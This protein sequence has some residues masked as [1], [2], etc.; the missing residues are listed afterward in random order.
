MKCK[1]LSG[2]VGLALVARASA[3]TA[4]Y[5]V[6]DGVVTTPPQID[7]LNFI[8]NGTFSFFL[9]S[10]ALPYQTANTITST[11]RGLMECDSGFRFDKYSTATGLHSPASNWVNQTTGTINCGVNT[12]LIFFI[13]PSTLTGSKC[14]VTASNIINRGT[15]NVASDGLT[16][17]KGASVDLSRGL[18]G[19][20]PSTF[21]SAFGSRFDGYWGFGD[22]TENPAQSFGT[23][24]FAP[25]HW[26]TNRYY[27]SLQTSLFLSPATPYSLDVI[28]GPSN[29]VVSAVFIRNFNPAFSNNVY[30]GGPGGIVTVEWVWVQTNFL[31]DVVSTNRMV[32]Q[33]SFGARTN[34]ALGR[35]G[36][37]APSTGSAASFT[38][39]NY[40]FGSSFF[41][42][43]TPAP[44][45]LPPGG[46]NNS[47]TT[48]EY[49]AYQAIFSGSSSLIGEVANQSFSQLPGRIEIDAS[50]YLDLNRAR[51]GALN[52]LS[53]KATNHFAGT[54]LARIA[55][56]F[57][58]MDLKTTNGMLVISNLMLPS[59]PRLE[60]TVDLFSA[61]WTNVDAFNFTNRYHVLLVNS[62][63]SPS[64]VPQFQELNLRSTNVIINDV[65]N[66]F[67]NFMSEAESLT[68]ASNSPGAD[69]I[70]GQINLL[71]GGILWP[72]ATPRLRY[73]TNEGVIS[74]LNAAFLGGSRTQPFF[75]TNYNEPYEAFV[76]RGSVSDQG[77]LIWAKY[78]ENRG[79]FL[80]GNGSFALEQCRTGL[81]SGGIIL[82]TSGDVAINSGSL[83][84]SNHGISAG[85]SLALSATNLLTD[86][87]VTNGNS[88]SVGDGFNLTARAVAG[89]LLG[90]TIYSV[91]PYN[92]EVVN[93]WAGQDRGCN[94]TGYTNNTAL[95]KVILDGGQFSQHTFTGT[96]TN[97]ALYVDYLELRNYMT[98]RDGGGNFLGIQ[99]DPNMKIY[100]AQAVANGVSIAEKL[101]GKNGGRFCWVSEYA[102][103]N[104]STNV[105]YPDGTTNLFNT[106]LVTSCNLDSDGDDLVNCADPTPIPRAQDLALSLS[107]VKTPALKAQLSWQ[108]WPYAQNYV[109]YKTSSGSTNWLTLTNF[110]SGPAGGP[111]SV[112][113]PVNP[114]NPRFYR[115]RVDP[116]HP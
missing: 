116:Y 28:T 57:A 48:N 84:I 7:A 64:T 8:N 5:Y 106:A 51:L 40:L 4:T 3:Q 1:L 18:V 47:N 88:W 82:A 29:R 87:G 95:G 22:V 86:T 21:T 85:R 9:G 44:T 12:N 60:G 34:F 80:C 72:A 45:G 68:V 77:S 13:G 33:D 53:I 24:A 107:L 75:S 6:N 103:Y 32:L 112:Q 99:L 30:F 83:T 91:A 90:T 55:A 23:F 62:A 35:T 54:V 110:V 61:R 97:N 108:T 115:V 114:S 46:F 70:A 101:D 76:N 31:T 15:I 27:Q 39:T 26:V 59:V 16:S 105:I 43:G 71:Y 41:G 65:L 56:P 100:F 20:Q 66:V 58:S 52:F 79:A 113:D 111:V 2:L 69:N 14:L 19:Q 81:F 50:K 11:N 37:A 102:G 78:F 10:F 96:G 109:Y 98:N 25:A 104:S 74:T 89:D 92:G 63:L 93:L 67:S 36:T 73:L 38:P 42:F 94:S 17:F 49:T